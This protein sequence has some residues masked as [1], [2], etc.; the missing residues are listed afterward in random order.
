MYR[1]AA[2][3]TSAARWYLKG[4]GR[5]CG[6]AAAAQ[7]PSPSAPGSEEPGRGN[8]HSPFAVLYSLA[9]RFAHAVFEP[10]LRKLAAPGETARLLVSNSHQSF[11]M[12][13]LF[14]SSSCHSVSWL[15]P[16]K[17]P[18]QSSLSRLLWKMT[19]FERLELYF[20][21]STTYPYPLGCL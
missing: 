15:L 13:L 18:Q 21:S 5:L 17:V 3:E 19:A 6:V 2:L 16:S 4:H 9:A 12:G 8:L 1:T 14:R 10:I 7:A 20:C 11:W